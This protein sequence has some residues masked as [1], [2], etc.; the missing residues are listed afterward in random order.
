[1]KTTYQTSNVDMLEHGLMV[2]KSYTRILKKDP[3]YTQHFGFSDEDL[4]ILLGLQ[5][6]HILIRH[7][8]IYHDCGKPFCQTTDENGKNHYPDHSTKSAEIHQK[9]FDCEIANKLIKNDM[10]FHSL[11][12]EELAAWLLI[13]DKETIASLY[14]TAWAEIF[15]NSAMF[16]GFESDS[17]KIKKKKLNS[18]FK[19]LNLLLK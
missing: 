19:K 11:K 3:E 14:L 17:F 2:N 16:G 10:A 18:S 5:H 12:S 8:H 7:Y 6:D 4:N 9:Y 15:S 13:Q 1:M